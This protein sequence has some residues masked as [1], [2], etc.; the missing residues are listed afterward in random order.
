MMDSSDTLVP[1]F[2]DV[3]TEPEQ[4]KSEETM[5][6]FLPHFPSEDD[7]MYKHDID[8]AHVKENPLD[9]CYGG[10]PA[11]P[12]KIEGT[13][14]INL[15]DIKIKNE[16][17]DFISHS[18][19]SE[20]D[21][22]HFENDDVSSATTG[23]VQIESVKVEEFPIKQEPEMDD[24]VVDDAPLRLKF[25]EEIEYS[26][27][28]RVKVENAPIS[29]NVTDIKTIQE[30]R[31][32]N[33]A[34]CK[35]QMKN[36]VYDGI[37]KTKCDDCCD[38]SLSERSLWL[39]LSSDVRLENLGE[40]INKKRDLTRQKGD[41]GEFTCEY[42]NKRFQRK[43][44]LIRH[45][46]IH[47]KE[48]KH[49]C[50][51]CQ[52]SFVLSCDLQRHLNM[53]SKEKK[54]ICDFCQKIFNCSSNLRVHLSIHKEE[55]Y[56][57]NV[58]QKTFTCSSNLSKHLNAHIKDKKYICNIC[59]KSFIQSCHLKSHQKIHT[60]EKKYV[61]HFCQKSF[62]FSSTLKQHLNIHTEDKKYVCNFCQKSFNYSS[63]FQIHINTHTKRKTYICDFCQKSF[64]CSSNL[65]KHR[66]I[67]TKEK[68]YDCE[69]CKKS[70]NWKSHLTR[71]INSIHKN[72]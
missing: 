35:K 53:H 51:L 41:V 9:S 44:N 62:N 13:N 61:C 4:N 31:M 2:I 66:N 52:K 11:D 36:L 43:F 18:S 54:Y 70:F 67:H 46:N 29:C 47:T 14:L 33:C 48:K 45:I 26:V 3:K 30:N 40:G 72:G 55:K 24:S 38:S 19:P 39:K 59:Q 37:M 17:D 22:L 7:A 10:F 69:E 1:I 60:N 6:L 20:G 42:C 56:V 23:Y 15:E 28:Q 68:L 5:R 25:E 21:S 58:C 12:L 32:E 34:T 71:H 16:P 49:I 57:C 65:K 8:S 27:L 50:N 64:N 63:N